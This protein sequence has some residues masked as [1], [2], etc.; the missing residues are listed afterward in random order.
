ML[1]QV[2]GHQAVWVGLG[3]AHGFKFSPT[4]GRLLAD[5]AVDGETTTDVSPFRLDRPRLVETGHRVS[6]L[7]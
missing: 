1:G 2:P 7:V 4:F 6:W 3:A 5:L